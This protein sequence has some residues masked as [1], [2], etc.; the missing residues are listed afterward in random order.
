MYVFECV[1][2]SEREG[3]GVTLRCK[4][5]DL[6]QPVE[7]QCAYGPFCLPHMETMQAVVSEWP[8]SAGLP[9]ESAY[10]PSLTMPIRPV[11]FSYC[12]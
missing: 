1:L 9:P 12:K 11:G 8:L 3:A 4:P 5:G 2:L 10:A 6:A 7:G